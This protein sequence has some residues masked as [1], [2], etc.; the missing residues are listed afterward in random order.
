MKVCC[1]PKEFHLIR[2]ISKAFAGNIDPNIMR[3]VYKFNMPGTNDDVQYIFHKW[4]FPSLYSL[5]KLQ[6]GKYLIHSW[7]CPYRLGSDYIHICKGIDTSWS[8]SPWNC[9]I[10]PS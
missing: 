1:N 6:C 8:Q 9:L 10:G 7:P 4:L 3:I 2:Q 5:Y